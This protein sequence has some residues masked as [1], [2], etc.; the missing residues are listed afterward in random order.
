MRRRPDCD[1]ITPISVGVVGD[2]QSSEVMNAIRRDR[3]QQLV[4]VACRQRKC[5]RRRIAGHVEQRRRQGYEACVDARTRAACREHVAEVLAQAVRDVD[6]GT[7][8]T[9]QR[10]SERQS[11]RGPP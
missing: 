1:S 5:P 4:V 3:E 7:G 9:A 11:G 6:G 8:D 10:G 2:F